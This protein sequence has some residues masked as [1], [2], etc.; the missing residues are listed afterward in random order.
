MNEH[1]HVS[2]RARESYTV[3]HTNGCLWS[4]RQQI[5]FK[6]HFC[7]KDLSQGHTVSMIEA[8]IGFICWN[9]QWRSK[10]SKALQSKSS[11]LFLGNYFISNEPF[12]IL[13]ST[14]YMPSPKTAAGNEEDGILTKKPTLDS[15]CCTLANLPQRH[16][17]RNLQ[18]TYC[19]VCFHTTLVQFGCR[20]DV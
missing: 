14:P 11:C 12:A 13:N 2:C 17:T 20:E 9:R 4:W 19:S 18:E 6:I 5:Q 1:Q 3:S 15:P 10:V 7:A 16:S 8:G